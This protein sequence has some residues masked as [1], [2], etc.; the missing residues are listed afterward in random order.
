MFTSISN[1]SLIKYLHMDKLFDDAKNWLCV[2]HLK[3]KK[4]GWLSYLQAMKPN[5]HNFNHG[6]ADNFS[7]IKIFVSFGN[8]IKCE[9]C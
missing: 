4:K 1:C 2:Q 9:F 6:T 3:K 5:L 8:F 7:L